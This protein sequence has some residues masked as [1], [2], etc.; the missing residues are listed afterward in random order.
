MIPSIN[1]KLIVKWTK[2][3]YSHIMYTSITLYHH[4]LSEASYKLTQ[5]STYFNPYI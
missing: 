2:D 5:S 3:S 4:L 1:I